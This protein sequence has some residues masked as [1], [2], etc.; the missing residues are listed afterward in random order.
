MS[1]KQP[2]KDI[3]FNVMLHGKETHW[4][5]IIL[6]ARQLGCSRLAYRRS[7]EVLL[8]RFRP[9]RGLS[10]ISTRHLDDV[11]SLREKDSWWLTVKSTDPNFRFKAIAHEI[12]PVLYPRFEVKL[13]ETQKRMVRSPCSNN[14]DSF[15]F[16]S[17]IDVENNPWKGYV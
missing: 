10:Q 8:A 3:I 16:A 9:L 2:F 11:D 7:T 1:E 6:N 13:R 5:Y 17:H 4:I 15:V 14:S 12:P